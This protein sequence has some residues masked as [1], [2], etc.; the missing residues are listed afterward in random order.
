VESISRHA[1]GVRVDHI[2]GLFRLYWIPR[3]ASPLTGTYV[4]YDF[5]A[6]VGIL[7]LEAQRASAVVIGEDLGTVEPWVQDVLAQKAVLGTSIVWFERDDD[8]YSPL[9]QDKY[10]QLALS[11]VNTHDL[12]PTLAYLR[13]DHIS[14]RARLGVLTRSVE[15]EQ[16]DDIEWQAR[17]LGAVADR[18]LLPQRDYLVDPAE[19]ASRGAEEDISVAL[20][21]YI[22][23]TP[24]ALSCTSL[25]DMVGDVRA[26]NQPGTTHELYPNWCVPLCDT[27]GTALLIE[28]LPGLE[29]F[30]R[31]AATSRKD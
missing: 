15:D 28:D 30:Q 5:E 12:P 17:V 8:D 4:S 1:G 2:L 22:A 23:G 13:G 25:V 27:N 11:S 18:G 19:R 21:R 9:P 20:H 7:A 29:F 6:M 10:R 24:S 31:L 26:Q 14:L 16:R 3:M